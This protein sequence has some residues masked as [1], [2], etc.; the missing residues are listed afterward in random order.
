MQAVKDDIESIHAYVDA[1]GESTPEAS[2]VGVKLPGSRLAK[3]PQRLPM[4]GPTSAQLY[5][6]LSLLVLAATD[7]TARVEL[8]SASVAAG[9][10]SGGGSRAASLSPFKRIMSGRP[11]GSGRLTL[12]YA[13]MRRI[14]SLRHALE[15]E[16]AERRRLEVL[17]RDASAREAAAASAKS[18]GV[19]PVAELTR[20]LETASAANASLRAQIEEL[21]AEMAHAKDAVIAHESRLAAAAT[22]AR[23]DGKHRKR[24]SRPKPAVLNAEAQTEPDPVIA[25]LEATLA[26]VRTEADTAA[27]DAAAQVAASSAASAA[28]ADEAATAQARAQ[29]SASEVLRVQRGAADD[30]AAANAAA[31]ELRLQL[32]H[33]HSELAALREHADAVTARRDELDAELELAVAKAR[34]EAEAASALERE[35]LAAARDVAETRARAAEKLGQSHAKD[36]ARAEARAAS[37]TRELELMRAESRDMVASFEHQ[38]Q[39]ALKSIQ[40]SSE[41]AAP[42]SELSGLRSTVAAL[43]SRLTE[44]AREKAASEDKFLGAVD[45]MKAHIARVEREHDQLKTALAQS[46]KVNAALRKELASADGGRSTLEFAELRSK[47]HRM[48]KRLAELEGA[49]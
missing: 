41:T 19:D 28:A 44:L 6:H 49:P 48:Q 43:E 5:Q 16:L 46:K 32:A 39:E 14:L 36:A 1:L 37:L 9:S 2:A 15:A 38:M 17:L 47:L 24:K 11:S 35:K 21:R 20:R 23:T 34:A 3:V 18:Y 10:G 30:V 33:A 8:A 31:A 42:A 26:R 7:A 13:I 40:A 22:A 12:F 25:E 29:A 45:R 27:A 4:V